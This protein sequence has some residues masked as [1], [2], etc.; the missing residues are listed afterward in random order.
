MIRVEKRPWMRI[1]QRARATGARRLISRVCCCY[2][3]QMTKAVPFRLRFA[4]F[5]E[6][7]A[8]AFGSKIE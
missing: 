4:N 2:S 3:S 5:P 1:P 6:K 7:T 8:S